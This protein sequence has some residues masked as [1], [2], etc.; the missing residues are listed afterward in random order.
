MLVWVPLPLG[1]N[2]P[3]AIGLLA[4]AVWALLVGVYVRHSLA[5]AAAPLAASLR[6]AWL[7]LALWLG[8]C[9]LSASQLSEACT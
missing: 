1:S 4:L 2:R 3:W 8:L 5:V 6:L 7:P 9:A